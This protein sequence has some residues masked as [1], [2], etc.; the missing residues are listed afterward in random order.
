MRTRRALT[1]LGRVRSFYLGLLFGDSAFTW[2]WT[3]ERR[4]WRGQV[5]C[6]FITVAF[7]LAPAIVVVLIRNQSAASALAVAIWE[8]ARQSETTRLTKIVTARLEIVWTNHARPFL[9]SFVFAS[10]K[11]AISLRQV[12]LKKHVGIWKEEAYC[13]QRR[14]PLIDSRIRGNQPLESVGQMFHIRVSPDFDMPASWKVIQLM[15]APSSPVGQ[16]GLP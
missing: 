2:A 3:G 9:C 15:S 10:Q 12:F 13:L 4:K 14:M 5:S 8:H 6:P 7:W 1:A 11:S 16:P